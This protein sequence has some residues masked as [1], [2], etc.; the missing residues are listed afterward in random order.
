MQRITIIGS[1]I[2]A[3]IA[4]L[5]F[6]NIYGLE[7]VLVKS[8]KKMNA[9]A[10]RHFAISPASIELLESLDIW[11]DIKLSATP[12]GLMHLR[13]GSGD[14]AKS[15]LIE[16]RAFGKDMLGMIV[17]EHNLIEALNKVVEQKVK[18]NAIKKSDYKKTISLFTKD[19]KT[20]PDEIFLVL[21]KSLDFL[22][23]TV[24]PNSRKIKYHESAL[25]TE[26]QT[27]QEIDPIAWQNFT[28]YGPL[29]LLPSKE[30]RYSLIWSL[31]NSQ[32]SDFQG[33][34]DEELL[35]MISEFFPEINFESAQLTERSFFPLKAFHTNNYF[36]GNV[37]LAGD[38][39]HQLL[40]LAGQ[41][42]NL[43]IADIGELACQIKKGLGESLLVSDRKILSKYQAKRH[44]ENTKM[45][46][47]TDLIDKAFRTNSRI[48]SN[49]LTLADYPMIKNWMIHQA[50]GQISK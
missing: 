30:N 8:E 21:D 24:S 2:T 28:Q 23:Q 20:R 32:I 7:V 13:S 16:A 42:L 11:G 14:N 34:T 41:G 49:L 27:L 22:I 50:G 43:G 29:A 40:P 15:L 37:V 39:A 36:K 5:V 26:I 25:V 1:G 46:L 35:G 18:A 45:I 10:S 44:K 17:Q 33:K 4:A 48:A 31:H 38:C 6:S 3:N 47:F 19:E 9:N 12:F